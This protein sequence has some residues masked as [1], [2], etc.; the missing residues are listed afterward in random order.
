MSLC[1]SFLCRMR[2]DVPHQLVIA[3][4]DAWRADPRCS[5]RGLSP[6]G[7][8]AQ[9]SPDGRCRPP[10]PPPRNRASLQDLT[11]KAH[12]A[13]HWGDATVRCGTLLLSPHSQEGSVAGCPL[14]HCACPVGGLHSSRGRRRGRE[15]QSFCRMYQVYRCPRAAV[16][17]SYTLGD[18][19]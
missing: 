11:V 17:N 8:F 4:A 1:L 14:G 5:Q 12:A 3:I 6:R 18:A 16:T 10:P 9:R 2:L 7:L 19:S 15:T 13:S